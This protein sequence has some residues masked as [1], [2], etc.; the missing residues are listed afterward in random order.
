MDDL[1]TK[2]NA[3]SSKLF[4]V[5]SVVKFNQKVFTTERGLG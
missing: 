2:Q 5:R 4:S 3:N 1:L